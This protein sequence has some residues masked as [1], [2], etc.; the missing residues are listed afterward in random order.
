MNTVLKI[1]SIS[2]NKKKSYEIKNHTL[3]IDDEPVELDD[4]PELVVWDVKDLEDFT[5]I[6]KDPET[7]TV[8]I[9]LVVFTDEQTMRKFFSIIKTKKD[10]EEEYKG[11]PYHKSPDSDQL[12]WSAPIEDL[13]GVKW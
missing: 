9:E 3:F 7:N 8:T 13:E 10:G 4:N 11:F 2:T 5:K 6:T 1:A 12:I